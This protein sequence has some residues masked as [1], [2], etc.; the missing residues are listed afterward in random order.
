[1]IQSN[2]EA[3]EQFGAEKFLELYEERFFDAM[4]NEDIEEM[5]KQLELYKAIVGED[6]L[7]FYLLVDLYENYTNID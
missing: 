7:M 5:E 2:R 4:Y 1:M 6:D 3:R